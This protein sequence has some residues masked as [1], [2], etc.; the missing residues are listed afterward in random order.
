MIGYSHML[1]SLRIIKYDPAENLR[2]Y[3]EFIGPYTGEGCG[4]QIPMELYKWGPGMAS[5]YWSKV[6]A[7]EAEPEKAG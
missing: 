6:R 7:P 1:F 5:S 3:D 4:E 2:E